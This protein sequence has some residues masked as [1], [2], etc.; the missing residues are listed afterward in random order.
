MHRAFVSSPILRPL[1]PLPAKTTSPPAF[2]PCFVVTD[3]KSLSSLR[4]LRRLAGKETRDADQQ[5][6]RPGHYRGPPGVRQDRDCPVQPPGRLTA[7]MG[8]VLNPEFW[9]RWLSIVVIDLTLA[10][11]NALVIALA[12]RTLPPKQQWLGRLWG[13]AGAV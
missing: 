6:R 10:G 13:T 9:A 3:G 5:V 12:V 1:R 8:A 11:D 2:P 4:P 7:L